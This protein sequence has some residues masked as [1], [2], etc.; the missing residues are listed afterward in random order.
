MQTKLRR[1]R[2]EDLA[3]VM[4]LL[5]QCD[6]PTSDLKPDS[7]NGFQL[8][9]SGGQLIAVAGLE[10]AGKSGLL[11]S[12]AVAPE[13]RR[14][15]LAQTLIARCETEACCAGIETVFLLTMTAADYFRKLG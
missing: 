15:G 5:M 10:N 14:K 8:A 12:V 13:W 4:A 11:R 3:S 9:E 2:A 1:A 7:M 6:L